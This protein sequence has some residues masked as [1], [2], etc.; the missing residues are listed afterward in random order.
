MFQLRNVVLVAAASLCAQSVMADAKLDTEMKKLAATSGCLTC[1]GVESAKPGPDG[2]M[3]IGPTWLDVATRYKGK[4][5]AADS[6]LRTVM[7]G[8]SPYNSHWKDKTSG[9]SMPPNAVAIKEADAKKLVK[10][11]LD[12][13]K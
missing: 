10:W 12:L 2:M 5:D 7:Q 9:L 13:K 4:K 8:S 3:P 6:L 11:I 1:H